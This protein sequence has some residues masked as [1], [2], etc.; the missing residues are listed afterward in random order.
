[1]SD[2]MTPYSGYFP[3]QRISSK[4]KTFEWGKKNIVA[5]SSIIFQ[6]QDWIRQSM[7]NKKINYDLANNKINEADIHKLF[8]PMG[9]QYGEFPVSIQH[10][11][12]AITKIN[13][14]V[15]EEWKRQFDWKVSNLNEDSINLKNNAILD[16]LLG[17]T[18]NEINN[19]QLDKPRLEKELK[20][21]QKYYTYDYKD[22]K[23]KYATDILNY[24]WWTDNFQYKFNRGFYDALIAGEEIYRTDIIAG[25]PVL[26]KCNPMNTFMLRNGD[27]QFAE[28]AEIIVELVYLPIGKIIEEFYDELTADEIDTL[29]KGYQYLFSS[30]NLI[31]YQSSAPTFVIPDDYFG[32][33]NVNGVI[34]PNAASSLFYGGYFNEYGE[35]R[36]LR[37]RWKSRLKRQ[38][39]TYFDEYGFEREDIVSEFYKCKKELGE[40]CRD[41]WIDQWW[42]GTQIGSDIYKRIKPR[43]VQFTDMTNPSTTGSG[44]VGTYYNINASKTLSLMDRMKPFQYLYNVFWNKLL[45]AMAR[46]NGPSK[47]MPFHLK[48]NDWTDDQWLY[49][50]QVLGILAIDPFNSAEEGPATGKLAGTFNSHLP[51]YIDSSSYAGYIGQ[52]I[53]LIDYV[54]MQIGDIAGITKQ[55]EGAISSTETLGGAERSITQ[56]SHITEIYHIMHENT[57]L[58]ALQA[59]LDTCKVAYKNKGKLKLSYIVDDLGT[60]YFELDTDEFAHTNYGIKIINS[61]RIQM[62]DQKLDML[63]Q[64]GLQNDKI[65]FSKA[66]ELYNTQSI[67]AKQR[68][69]EDFEEE[70]NQMIQQQQQAQIEAENKRAEDMLSW[71][72]E[73]HEDMLSIELEKLANDLEKVKLQIDANREKANNDKESD[74]LWASIEQRKQDINNRLQELKIRTDEK[75]KEKDIQVKKQIKSKK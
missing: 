8:N 12:K 32:Q 41:I 44:Y 36:V 37:C 49:Y 31:G 68:K 50:E 52:L 51:Q 7:Y 1:M 17:L 28:D 66:I 13:L 39:R 11:N 6:R 65:N 19:S 24:H 72:K 58:R 33:T 63:I 26:E 42:E 16:E 23:E 71:E 67:S 40:T 56:S 73:K 25:R 48:P 3:A 57:K 30:N 27:S 69:I 61:A 34:E 29:E 74:R 45:L 55:R 60:N 15:G 53:N 20:R 64:A 10:F 35:V 62:I 59:F 43:D 4:D 38:I 70:N 18:I 9:I 14:L 46:Y 22:I 5:A 54:D 47:V 2:G 21:L 75:L